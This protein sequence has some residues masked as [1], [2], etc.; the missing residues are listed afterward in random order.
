MSR[1]QLANSSPLT[2][3]RGTV[4]RPRTG[5]IGQQLLSSMAIFSIRQWVQASGLLTI[6][7]K[8][9]QNVRQAVPTRMQQAQRRRVSPSCD[10]NFKAMC[11]VGALL[12]LGL[13]PA[14]AHGVSSNLPQVQQWTSL[15]IGS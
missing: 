14:C 11:T 3:V 1:T 7:R 5:S 10:E 9:M 8:F 13:L 2:D 6:L 4:S 12:P 15:A